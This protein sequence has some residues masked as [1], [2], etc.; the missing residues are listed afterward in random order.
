MR[1]II[2]NWILGRALRHLSARKVVYKSTFK[3][4]YNEGG[5]KT[6]GRFNIMLCLMM[7]IQSKYDK[8]LGIN[9]VEL[10]ES[11]ESVN[12]RICLNKPSKLIIYRDEIEKE[13]GEVIKKKVVIV[14][15]YCEKLY[16]LGFYNVD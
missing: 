3:N 1:K 10:D 12:I 7:V 5:V 11:D 2:N 13:L 16:G 8:F 4:Q 6:V 15:K 9:S 14:M